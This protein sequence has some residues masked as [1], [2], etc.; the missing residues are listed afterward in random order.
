M[1]PLSTFDNHRIIYPT[2]IVEEHYGECSVSTTT[3]KNYPLSSPQQ[4]QRKSV[5][6]DQ[7]VKVRKTIHVFD[8]TDEEL[9]ACW[10]NDA[11]FANIREDIAIE[12]DFF[13]TRLA[14]QDNNNNQYCSRGL[15]SFSS[16]NILKNQQRAVIS[17]EAVYDEQEFQ[18]DNNLCDDECIG[19]LYEKATLKSRALARYVGLKD[20]LEVQRS[21]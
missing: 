20:A 5:S 9:Y 7:S 16:K 3:K 11:E 18:W 10:Y 19:R 13:R 2:T 6:F 8:Y 21:R 1:P 4:K 12:V 14:Q 15:E 17:R